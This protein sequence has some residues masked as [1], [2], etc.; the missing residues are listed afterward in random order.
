MRYSLQ[1]HRVG[2]NGS[3][4]THMHKTDRGTGLGHEVHFSQDRLENMSREKNILQGRAI[5]HIEHSSQIITCTY[6]HSDMLPILED[7]KLG[8]CFS[9]GNGKV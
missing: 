9:F 4:L 3:D 6:L 5:K 2:C 7:I 8:V 1:G